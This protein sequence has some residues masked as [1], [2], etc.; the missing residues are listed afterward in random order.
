MRNEEKLNELLDLVDLMKDGDPIDE[1]R[2]GDSTDGTFYHYNDRT[3]LALKVALITARPLLLVGP[4]GCGKSS[5][6][7]Y[8]ARN[9]RLK[10]FRYVVT[11]TAEP[12]DLLWRV[13]YIRRLSDAQLQILKSFDFYVEPGTL[14]KAFVFPGER[15]PGD[16]RLGSLIL[17]DEIDKASAGFANSLLVALGSLQFDVPPLGHTIR[18]L[19]DAFILIM[20]TSNE[21]REL[22]PAFTRRCVTLRLRYPTAEELVAITQDRWPTWMESATFRDSVRT[23]AARLARGDTNAPK[24]STAEFLDLVEVLKANHISPESEDWHTVEGLVLL[25][26]EVDELK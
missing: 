2:I 10:L 19:K 21:E 13:D 18:A 26:R 4:P 22:P 14:W 9:L 20:M 7:P 23:L 16:S 24:V 8:V 11:E 12:S 1:V 3:K 17:I 15:E 25:N 5:L 6:A